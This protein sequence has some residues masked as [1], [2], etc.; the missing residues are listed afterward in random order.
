MRQQIPM[1]NAQCTNLVFCIYY[2][3]T[4]VLF[5]PYNSPT[6]S[7]RTKMVLG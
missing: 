1:L 5:C 6:L 4:R 3:L 2:E 7:K